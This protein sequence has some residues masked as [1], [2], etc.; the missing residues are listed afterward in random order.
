MHISDERD[1]GKK[2]EKEREGGEG[3]SRKNS[4]GWPDLDAMSASSKWFRVQFV[5]QRGSQFNRP[6]AESWD[7]SGKPLKD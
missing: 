1:K 6:G 2:K 5:M 4:V 3:S 7:R